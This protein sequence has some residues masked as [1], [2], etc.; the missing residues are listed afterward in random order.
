MNAC[1]LI[2]TDQAMLHLNQQSSKKF[3]GGIEK[4]AFLHNENLSIMFANIFKSWYVLGYSKY[5]DPT[6][7]KLKRVDYS[8]GTN[9]ATT[10]K[11]V[12]KYKVINI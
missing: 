11:R 6:M 12:V 10:S 7:T 3:G 2:I 4:T 9:C 1:A 5:I 8:Y